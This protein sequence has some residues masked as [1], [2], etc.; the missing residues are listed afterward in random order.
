MECCVLRPDQQD[1]KETVFFCVVFLVSAS[2]QRV[3]R[4]AIKFL[5]LLYSYQELIS[6]L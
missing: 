4:E 5:E 3:V 6:N 1:H 2:G